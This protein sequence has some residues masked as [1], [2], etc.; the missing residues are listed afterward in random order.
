MPDTVHRGLGALALV[1]TAPLLIFMAALVKMGSPGPALYAAERMGVG[2]RPF[3]CFKFRTMLWQPEADGSAITV[4]DDLRVTRVG[5]VLR[6][7][8]LDELPQ[9]INVAKGEMNLIG[10]RPEDPR[11]VDFNDP[12]HRTVFMSKPGITGLAQLAFVAEA[13]LLGADPVE[14]ER[15]YRA[16]ILPRKVALDATYLSRRSWRLD[17]W[18][19]RRTI[20]AVVG[21]GSVDES[22][23]G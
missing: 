12:L 20:L 22:G 14:A 9:L 3:R 7:F 23:V 11:Y 6:R 19:L 1:V 8:R 2:G 18:I 15:R 16:T 17:L 5:G 4:R 13:Q 21:R 10:P